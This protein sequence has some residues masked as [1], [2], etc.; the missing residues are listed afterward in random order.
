MSIYMFI[1]RYDEVGEGVRHQLLEFE[2]ALEADAMFGTRQHDEDVISI[3]MIVGTVTKVYNQTSESAGP[4][5]EL[6]SDELKASMLEDVPDLE[7]KENV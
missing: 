6:S 5:R 3:K 4:D 2:D 1:E 7:D